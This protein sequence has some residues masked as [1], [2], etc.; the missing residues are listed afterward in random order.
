[1]SVP[2]GTR[3]KTKTKDQDQDQIQ[4]RQECLSHQRQQPMPHLT[5]QLDMVDG[6]MPFRVVGQVSAITGMTIEATDLTLP[7]GSLCRIHS[8]GGKSSAAEVIGFRADRTLLM[9]LS[10]TAGVARGDRIE[11]VAASPRV[12]VS[13]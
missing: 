2:P 4:D 5:A 10:N 11:N 1:M 7:L 12:W 13:D 8:F 9:P 6:S 3:P